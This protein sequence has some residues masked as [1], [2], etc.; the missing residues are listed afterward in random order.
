[1]CL[2]DPNRFYLGANE[3]IWL[4]FFNLNLKLAEK[5][6]WGKFQKALQK[7]PWFLERGTV[8][9]RTNLVYQPNKDIKLGIGSTEEHALSI[10]VMFCLAGETKILT[11]NGYMPIED[12]NNKCTR[13][14]T[15]NKDGSISLT[16]E[17]VLITQTNTVSE[18]IEIEMEN[19]Y[20]FK[21]TPEHRL[22]LSD[23]TYKQAKDLTTDDDLQTVVVEN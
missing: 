11:E 22:L 5:T 2:K 7:S 4:L 9:G 8:T 10:A 6:M 13:V 23:G 12:L 21:C 14:F 18:L 3:T 20:T 16:D 1:M 19:G 17:P 15:F